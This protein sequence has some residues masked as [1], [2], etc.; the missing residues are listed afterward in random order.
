MLACVWL[1]FSAHHRTISMPFLLL[2]A[3]GYLYVGG[4]SLWV[5]LR[6]HLESRRPLPQPA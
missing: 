5:H 2:F 6:A 1:S 4:T 3:A